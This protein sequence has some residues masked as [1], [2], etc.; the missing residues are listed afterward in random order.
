LYKNIVYFCIRLTKKHKNMK[1]LLALLLVA[2][3]VAFVAC[4][5]SKKDQEAKEKAK[6]DSIKAAEK[7]KKEADSLAAVEKEKRR[8]DSLRQDSINKSKNRPHGG[9][10]QGGQPPKPPQPVKPTKPVGKG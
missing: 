4:G 6:Q 3:M 7:A 8:M 5:P 2:G 1:K 9:G 10:N